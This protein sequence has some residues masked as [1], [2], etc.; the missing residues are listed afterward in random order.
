MEASYNKQ[1]PPLSEKSVEK[2]I[3]APAIATPPRAT[4]RGRRLL[5]TFHV[6][7]GLLGTLYLVGA[8]TGSRT[9]LSVSAPHL[10]ALKP[11]GPLKPKD[12]EK[13]F[14]YAVLLSTA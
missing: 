9:G 2:A 13:L 5:K 6:L 11:K 1:T 4:R 8:L 3:P 7:G 12:A 14:L 10:D